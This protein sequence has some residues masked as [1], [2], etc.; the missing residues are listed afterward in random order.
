MA[1][2][3]GRALEAF[4]AGSKMSDGSGLNIWHTITIV[5]TVTDGFRLDSVVLSYREDGGDWMTITMYDL[6]DNTFEATIGPFA[7]GTIIQYFIT[8]TDD[9]SNNNVAIDNNSG[10][11]YSFGVSDSNDGDP[12]DGGGISGF[13]TESFSFFLL[14]GTAFIISRIMHQRKKVSI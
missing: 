4:P 1:G 6:G 12:K 7:N 11:F 14:L 8:A 3:N 13:S 5:V 2:F 9:S 10:V